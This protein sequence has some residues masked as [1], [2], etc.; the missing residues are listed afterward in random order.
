VDENVEGKGLYTGLSIKVGKMSEEQNLTSPK[1]IGAYL[2]KCREEKGISLLHISEVTKIS[3]QLL[4]AIEEGEWDKLYSSFFLVNFLKAY[5]KTINEPWEPVVR[6]GEKFFLPIEK[7]KADRYR[8]LLSRR[9]PLFPN[10][11]K[12]VF[13]LSVVAI[14]LL[15]LAGGLFFSNKDNKLKQIQVAKSVESPVEIPREAITALQNPSQELPPSETKGGGSVSQM[16]EPAVKASSISSPAGDSRQ[17]VVEAGVS[18]NTHRLIIEATNEVW[19]KVW[20]D[21]TD[22]P[23]SKLLAEGERAEF[24]VK[25]RAKVK[26]GD[27]A[28]ARIIWDDKV[29]EKLGRKGR[30]ITMNFPKAPKPSKRHVR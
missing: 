19:V 1:E 11:G 6:L 26:L 5:C 3:P 17:K 12:V 4:R 7:K 20:L 22:T 14:S 24:E 13:Y 25:E 21:N 29:Y 30:V 9:A 27:A 10:K 16:P 18:L 2:R 8:K 28:G 23:V 15:M